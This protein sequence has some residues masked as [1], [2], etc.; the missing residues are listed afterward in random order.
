MEFARAEFIVLAAVVGA[1]EGVAEFRSFCFHFRLLQTPSDEIWGGQS[2]M[3]YGECTPERAW[4]VQ[5]TPL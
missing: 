3:L 2:M 4:S 5:H 1:S